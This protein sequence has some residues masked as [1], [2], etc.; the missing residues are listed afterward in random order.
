MKKKIECGALEGE[1]LISRLA[2][3]LVAFQKLESAFAALKEN[4]AENLK[5]MVFVDEMIKNI[6]KVMEERR[7]I[8]RDLL[9]PGGENQAP[10]SD[11]E[12]SN[13]GKIGMS[14]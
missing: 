4:F 9:R 10:T 8:I 13:D 2:N 11:I 14:S 12:N 3:I 6:G 7:R 5:G 1:G